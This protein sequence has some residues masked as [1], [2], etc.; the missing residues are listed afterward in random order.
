MVSSTF[1]RH[2]HPLRLPLALA[3]ALTFMLGTNVYGEDVNIRGL[4]YSN[5]TVLKF[6]DGKIHFRTSSRNL[7][8]KDLRDT[9]S[10]RIEDFPS[11]QRA[12]EHYEDAD[13][14][15][16][17]K[18][19]KAVRSK[20]ARATDKAKAKWLGQWI[21]FRLVQCADQTGDLQTALIAYLSLAK[22][23]ADAYLLRYRPDRSLEKLTK[24]IQSKFLIKINAAISKSKNKAARD[25]LKLLQKELKA[26]RFGKRIEPDGPRP[27]GTEKPVEAKVL[28]LRVLDGPDYQANQIVKM[29]RRGDFPAVLKAVDAQLKSRDVQGRSLNLYMRG[30]AQMKTG[31]QASDP[32]KK[33]KWYKDAGISFMRV[34]IVYPRSPWA[35][36]C[37]MEAGYIHD[38]IG[39]KD[40][41]DALYRRARLYIEP[42]DDPHLDARLNELFTNL[43]KPASKGQEGAA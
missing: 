7:V 40:L 43:K 21:D 3:M 34:A 33:Q 9:R 23:D 15:K 19:Y 1:L 5:V 6:A 22:S 39:R 16:A 29:L 35:G 30:L 36:H 37:Q 13:Y 8:K 28:Y 41:V 18:L 26:I 2:L 38:K 11:L 14:P 17:I 24:A 32:A 12:E 25:S 10:L 27:K 4:W 31:D 42:E 20:A